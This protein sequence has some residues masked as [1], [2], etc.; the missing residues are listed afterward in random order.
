MAC[1]YRRVPVDCAVTFNA[2]PVQRHGSVRFAFAL[3]LLII[4]HA[5]PTSA[6]YETGLNT[7]QRADYATAVR[8]WRPLAEQGHAGAQYYLGLCYD[9]SKGVPQDFTTARQWYEKAATQ[10]HAGA[11]N[12]LGGLYEFGHGVPRNDVLAYMWY[13]LAAAHPAGDEWRDQA[14]ENL[15]EI[16]D[17][18]TSAQIAEA[19]KRVREWKPIKK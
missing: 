1:T 17:H 18:M 13:S 7:F 5:V 2:D 15:D 16:A 19:K 8:E 6:D 12:N 14:A 4:G 9:F 11:Q 3:L 10:G